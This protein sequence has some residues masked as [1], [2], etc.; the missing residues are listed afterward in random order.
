MKCQTQEE[1]EIRYKKMIETNDKSLRLS[2]SIYKYDE[3]EIVENTYFKLFCYND[4]IADIF[5]TVFLQHFQNILVNNGF[6]MSEIG[7]I[8]NLSCLVEIFRMK[9]FGVFHEWRATVPGIGREAEFSQFWRRGS[10][11]NVLQRCQNG[12]CRGRRGLKITLKSS[13]KQVK[14]FEA[15]P[16]SPINSSLADRLVSGGFSHVRSISRVGGGFARTLASWGGGPN[17]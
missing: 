5:K 16:P 4:F 10:F 2:Q 13:K 15:H 3:T 6:V 14:V 1:L 12:W 17:V 11:W 9:K 8:I 7:E